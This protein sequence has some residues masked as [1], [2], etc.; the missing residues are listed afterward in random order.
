MT[1]PDCNSTSPSPSFAAC[2][3][4]R[5]RIGASHNVA[6]QSP[7]LHRHRSPSCNAACLPAHTHL[8][9][10]L[11]HLH[12]Q[13]ASHNQPN[14]LQA[15]GS[16]V[17][18]KSTTTPPG[19]L[20]PPTFRL[21]AE[22]ANRLRHGGDAPPLSSPLPSQPFFLSFFLS[23][24]PFFLPSRHLTHIRLHHLH[25][26]VFHASGAPIYR[27]LTPTTMTTRARIREAKK[28][29]PGHWRS[30]RPPVAAGAAGAQASSRMQRD[31]VCCWCENLRGQCLEPKRPL[32][33]RW[34]SNPRPFGPVP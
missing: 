9:P 31:S 30:S 15:T 1:S 19:G 14:G 10:H 32:W 4:A 23:F 22:R 24:F 34:D 27:A 25:Y 16:V 17:L 2:Q 6:S 13:V 26:R 18:I 7:P 8:P 20:E 11:Y 12:A 29:F 21:T 5:W 33:Q 28:P 3:Q